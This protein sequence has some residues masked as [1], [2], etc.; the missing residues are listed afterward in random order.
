VE[1]TDSSRSRDRLFGNDFKRRSAKLW[2]R[3]RLGLDHKE[4]QA[5]IK[6]MAHE[7][8]QLEI[9][10]SGNLELEPIRRQRSQ[11][12]DA[13]YWKGI[14]EFAVRLYSCLMSRWPCPCGFPHQVSLR[15]DIRS[16]SPAL[17]K[18]GV[19]FALDN[20]GS[21]GPWKWRNTEI[22]GVETK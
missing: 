2:K 15:L 20:G 22:R 13:K 1:K 19:L 6:E 4:F 7:N 16:T 8:L 12:M 14:R 9:L 11:D 17:I 3:V 21:A 18:F 5:L 10:T